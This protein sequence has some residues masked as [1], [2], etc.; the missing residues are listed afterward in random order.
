MDDTREQILAILHGR[1]RATVGEVASDLGVTEATVRRHMEILLREGKIA[2]SIER[3]GPGRPNHIF[4]PNGE[5][6]PPTPNGLQRL[7]EGLLFEADGLSPAELRALAEGGSLA[8]L[9]VDRLAHRM[10]LSYGGR[11]LDKRG[12]QRV[13]ETVAALN[14]EGYLAEQKRSQDGYEIT[15]HR[16][17]FGELAKR[18]PALCNL[19]GRFVAGLLGTPV[20]RR[21]AIAQGAPECRF[22]LRM[23]PL[24]SAA[25]APPPDRSPAPAATPA[26]A[27]VIIKS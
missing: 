4:T 26:G 19:E 12:D 24:A 27:G 21:C 1:Q 14:E 9:L 11:L 3:G 8:G 20:E 6:M 16:C 5:A 2:R 18:Y 23:V 17:P 7:A 22:S 10:A 15:L 13:D 25:A